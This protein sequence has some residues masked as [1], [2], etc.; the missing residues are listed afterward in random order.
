MATEASANSEAWM[1][2]VHERGGGDLS[3]PQ[4]AIQTMKPFEVD[5]ECAEL[6]LMFLQT[7]AV[8][9]G[10]ERVAA[11]FDGDAFRNQA[12]NLSI[13]SLA[14]LSESLPL[15]LLVDVHAPLRAYI[16]R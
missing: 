9:F 6:A 12:G 11:L 5:A 15:I 8:L 2:S 1:W 4:W 14:L 16:I 13:Q 10:L 7:F 3:I